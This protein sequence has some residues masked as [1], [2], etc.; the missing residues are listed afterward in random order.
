MYVLRVIAYYRPA[1]EGKLTKTEI[2]FTL[3][4][5]DTTRF[6]SDSGH[7]RFDCDGT[8]TALHIRAQSVCWYACGYPV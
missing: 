2:N 1:G 3:R 4:L 6:S 7:V 5:Q 8:T